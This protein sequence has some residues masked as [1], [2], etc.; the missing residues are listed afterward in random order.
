MHKMESVWSTEVDKVLNVGYQL[1]EIGLR[2][3]A[4][5][6]AQALVALEK[7]YSLQVPV[8]GGD[9]CERVNNIIRPNYDSWYCDPMPDEDKVDFLL[10]SIGKAKEY[11]TAYK[12]REPNETFFVLVPDA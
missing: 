8:L 7:L 6:K 5:T 11:I 3:W 2:N 12:A 1:S 10:R 4:L 9:V